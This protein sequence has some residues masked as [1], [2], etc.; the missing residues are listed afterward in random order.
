MSLKGEEKKKARIFRPKLLL[1]LV[2]VV[3]RGVAN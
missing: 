2:V 3:L 1:V